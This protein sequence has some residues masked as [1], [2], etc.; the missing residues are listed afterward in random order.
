MLIEFDTHYKW[1]QSKPEIS[2][3]SSTIELV[4]TY[5][6]WLNEYFIMFNSTA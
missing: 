6:E 1:V 4:Q 2:E 5:Q 3:K